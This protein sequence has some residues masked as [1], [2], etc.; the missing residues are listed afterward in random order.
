MR[1][2]ANTKNKNNVIYIDGI[3]VPQLNLSLK[4]IQ[5]LTENQSTAFNAYSKKR[6]LLLHG[7]AGTGKT[8]ISLYL[9]LSSILK[10]NSEYSKVTIVRSVV[11]TRDI[12]FLPGDQND[13]TKQYE[14]P[15][16]AICSELFGR[17]D[18]YEVLKH[19]RLVEF[20]TTSFIRGTTI[21]NSIVIVDECNN[22]TFHE[23]DSIITRVGVN[24]Q[25]LFCGDYRQSD[26]SKQQER[27]GLKHFMTILHKMG[28]FEHLE[29]D[30]EDI[31]RSDLV[32]QY[33]IMKDKLGYDSKII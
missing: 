7:L 3:K 17:D 25:I 8:F 26:L 23:L 6:N 21:N 33:I 14:L 30:E 27:E 1:K 11:P 12:G 20:V 10:R 18:A 28:C 5:P 9:G 2:K 16:K 13:K 29:F 15:Y 22:M 19:H 31:L 32:K 4:K 24:C